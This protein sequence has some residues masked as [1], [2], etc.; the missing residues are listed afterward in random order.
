MRHINVCTS[1][2]KKNSKIT[3]TLNLQCKTEDMES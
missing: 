2:K 1:L 3:K